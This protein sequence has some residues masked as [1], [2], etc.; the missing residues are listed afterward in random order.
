MGPYICHP[1]ILTRRRMQK[2][3]SILLSF[4]FMGIVE[5]GM[6]SFL[7]LRNFHANALLHQMLT[8][9]RVL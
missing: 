8:C 4:S 2:V 6:C 7:M 5:H 3:M 1:S 9:Q